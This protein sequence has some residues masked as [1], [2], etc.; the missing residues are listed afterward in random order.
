MTRDETKEMF[1]K[2]ALVYDNFEAVS[3]KI[4]FWHK[5]LSDIPYERAESNLIKHIQKSK[6]SPTIADIRNDANIREG[7]IAW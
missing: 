2:I 7:T 3:E 4:D 6:Y 1:K 5:L